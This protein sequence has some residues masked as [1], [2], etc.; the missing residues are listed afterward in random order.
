MSITD[1]TTTDRRVDL[2]G[3][4]ARWSRLAS[5]GLAAAAAGAL[6]MFGAGAAWGLDDLGFFATAALMAVIG[7]IL[8]RQ[9][10][11]LV[12][13]VG[14]I[15]AVLVG[16]MLFWTAFGL[17]EP[18]SFFDFVPGVL[19]LPGAVIA[20]GA[21]I[22]SIR[23]QRRDDVVAGATG[24]ERTALLVGG[25][26]IIGLTVLSGV[27]TLA[28]RETVDADRADTVVKMTDFEFDLE[29]G[30]LAPGDVVL[31]RNDDPFLHTFDID[32]LGISIEL[33]PGSERL[34]TIPESASGS[35]VLYCAPHT[36][37]TEDPAEDDMATRLDIG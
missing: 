17:A 34:V 37:D 13:V 22:A 23:A 8:L 20:L 25:V 5:W 31:V 1:D 4:R 27:L 36:S 26:A 6:I 14:V 35:Y 29:S 21:G 33:G 7:A 24:G 19:V 28:G 16:G 12:R 3:G 9:R 30:E 15:L 2:R 11:T 32:E 10:R 18:D